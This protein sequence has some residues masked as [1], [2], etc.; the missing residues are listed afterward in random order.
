MTHWIKQ[1]GMPSV[2]VTQHFLASYSKACWLKEHTPNTKLPRGK[3]FGV[4]NK[5][6][7]LTP[8]LLQDYSQAESHILGVLRLGSDWRIQWEAYS[9]N[10]QQALVLSY[11]AFLNGCRAVSDFSLR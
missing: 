11:V 7:L 5:W 4:A 8:N 9:C 3:N 1:Y 2:L 10:S 6:A